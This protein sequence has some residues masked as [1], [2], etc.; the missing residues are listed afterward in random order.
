MMLKDKFKKYIEESFDFVKEEIAQDLADI[1]EKE[2]AEIK[3]EIFAKTAILEDLHERNI[4]L[5]KQLDDVQYLDRDKVEDILLFCYGYRYHSPVNRADDNRRAVDAICKLAIPKLEDT[6]EVHQEA[7]DVLEEM[8]K[9][10]R[11]EDQ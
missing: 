11:E 9:E 7:Q 1:T 5:E 10:E 4:E 8:K 2:M 3:G 6:L